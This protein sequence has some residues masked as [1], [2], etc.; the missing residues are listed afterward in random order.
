MG[1]KETEEFK[2]VEKL[3]IGKDYISESGNII[4]IDRKGNNNSN[5]FRC[6]NFAADIICEDPDF[7][8]EATAEDVIA[9]FEAH[10]VK[11]YG[12]DWETMKIKERHP[13]LSSSFV[14]NDGSWNVEISKEYG[15]W[16]V[17][18]K[19]GL[20]YYKGIWAE[21]L[22]EPRSTDWTPAPEDIEAMNKK[23]KASETQIGGSHY[24][25]MAI[26]PTEFI[27]KMS[28]RIVK[29]MSATQQLKLF[30]LE[31]ADLMEKYNMTIEAS[32]EFMGYAECGEDIQICFECYPEYNH[33][34]YLGHAEENLGK[35]IDVDRLR[36]EK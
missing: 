16:D 12:A 22:E 18:N 28:E 15:G 30:K 20:L 3:E 23:E 24:S 21:R 2:G 35:Y 33:D 11:R 25:D 13:A 36:S 31:L 26:Q 29:G 32:D 34:E 4:T 6:D 9:I 19:N 5:G 1:I 8:R 27:H 10:L 17:Y 14:I 7:W